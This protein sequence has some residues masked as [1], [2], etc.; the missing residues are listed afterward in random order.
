MIEN[1]KKYLE[2]INEKLTTFFHKQKPYI[3]C[4][5]GCAK[6]CQ[7]AEFPFSQMEVIYL[8]NGVSKLDEATKNIIAENV[9]KVKE[10]KR[11]FNG[12]GKFLYDCPFLINNKCCVYEYRGIICRTFGLLYIGTNGK[13]QVPFCSF[14]GLNY[15]NVL[16]DDKSTISAEKYKASG[17]EAEPVAF[18]IRYGFLTESSFEQKFNFA[19]GEKKPLIDWFVE[20][21]DKQAESN[22]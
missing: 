13:T 10:A 20:I 7:N 9:K 6:C 8:M 4:K 19:F 21:D 14:Q 1:Y 11:N 17:I 3:C 2:F 16:A 18:N 5:E 15:A 22:N 12:E